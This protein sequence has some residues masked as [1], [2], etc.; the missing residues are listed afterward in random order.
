LLQALATTPMIIP[1]LP[2]SEVEFIKAEL[3]WKNGND[4]AAKTAYEK[5]VQAA[6]EQWVLQ[7]RR[8]IFQILPPH[9]MAPWIVLCCRSTTHYY[10]VDFQQWFEY[11]RTGLP[12]LPTE[13]GMGN[14]KQ[15]PSRFEYP[16]P[17]W[18]NNPEN[19]QQ[20]VE[21]MGADDINTKVGGRSEDANF[22]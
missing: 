16:L 14:N 2:Y 1:I 9:G 4:A 10:F 8:T 15:M 18:T 11:R 19:Y 22:R 12:V 17:V 7:C 20:A 6:M 21:S 13:A 5:G 3:E